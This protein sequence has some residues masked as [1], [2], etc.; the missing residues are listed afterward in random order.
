LLVF[1]AY[2]ESQVW[3]SAA[4]TAG[5]GDDDYNPLGDPN[6]LGARNNPAGL[7]ETA[8]FNGI[9]LPGSFKRFDVDITV[10]ELNRGQRAADMAV[11]AN[12][13]NDA[14]PAGKEYLIAKIRI[15][16]L[17]SSDDGVV[18][19]T[20]WDFSAF[21]S[22]GIEYTDR[23]Y[24]RDIEDL[25]FSQMYPDSTQERYL[26]F[27]VDESDENPYIVAFNQSYAKADGSVW[28][29]AEESNREALIDPNAPGTR[30]NPVAI[31]APHDITVST[32]SDNY[33]VRL[34]VLDCVRGMFAEE[35]LDELGY[36]ISNLN[37]GMELLI[38]TIGIEALESK[39]D[40]MIR[41]SDYDFG[42][43]SE[44]GTK[45]D[46]VSIYGMPRLS[47]M[48][49]GAVQLGFLSFQVSPFDENPIVVFK[50]T[51]RDPGTW[52]ATN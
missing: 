19:V 29:S 43:V 22:S 47:D 9:D 38:L 20:D 24:I 12:T 42:L 41:I 52:F 1:P 51:S 14:P 33:T 48:Y 25:G 49:E 13:Y 28:F 32:F 30:N 26:V 50:E 4:Q 8:S 10:T 2:G 45:Y 40:A 36:R 31:L 37:P 6:R 18:D 27:M 16:A 34:T 3:F 17:A 21:S 46:R 39:D 7:N 35:D 44:S 11:L 15:D 5:F 23:A